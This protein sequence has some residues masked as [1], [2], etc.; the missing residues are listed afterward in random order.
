MCKLGQV[1]M[2]LVDK[3]LFFVFLVYLWLNEE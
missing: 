1:S 2:L 3:V